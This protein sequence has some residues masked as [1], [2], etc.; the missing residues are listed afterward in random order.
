MP[1]SLP[2]PQKINIFAYTG[3]NNPPDMM[4]V[5]AES[6]LRLTFDEGEPER[7]KRGLPT[8]NLSS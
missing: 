8:V 1:V 2:S 3:K 4:P 5:S 7:L 6:G